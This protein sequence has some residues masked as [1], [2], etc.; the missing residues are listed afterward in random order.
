MKQL[1]KSLVRKTGYELCS[2]TDSEKRLAESWSWNECELTYKDFQIACTI[3]SGGHITIDEA[4]LLT[5]LV[6]ETRSD[7]PIIE[8][9]TLFGYSTTVLCVAKRPEQK[10]FTVDRFSWN[11]HG[12]NPEAHRIGTLTALEDARQH[13]NC[14]VVEQDKDQFYATY[15]GPAP[16]LFFCDANHEYEPTL[17]DLKWARSAGAHII[18]G[19]DYHEQ[20]F[21]GVFRAVNELGGP[22]ELVGSLFVL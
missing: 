4:Q 14:I 1:I 20:Q 9:G 16:A 11:P 7:H 8:I 15:S 10:L 19:H 13:H 18:C 12:I 6:R 21:P 17:A 5:K 3:A 22:R 2:L